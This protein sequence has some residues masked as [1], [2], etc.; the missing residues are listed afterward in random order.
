MPLKAVYIILTVNIEKYQSE[1][2]RFVNGAGCIK[3]LQ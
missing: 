2:I 1:S 3:E